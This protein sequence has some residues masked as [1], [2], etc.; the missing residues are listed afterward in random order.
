MYVKR[1]W[2]IHFDEEQYLALQGESF[3][4]LLQTPARLNTFR[5]AMAEVEQQLEP[6]ACW[7]HFPIQK[8]LHDKLVLATGSRIGGGPVVAVIGG[9]SELIVAICTIGPAVD[10]L[11]EMAQ[12]QRQHFRMMIL[13][14]LGAWAVDMVRQELCHWLEEDLQRQGLRVSTPLSPG[15]SAWSVK[16]QAVIFSLLDASQINVSLS[17]SMIMSPVKSLSL[18]IGTGT[19]PM[20][21]EGATNCD[22]CSIK[23][24]CTYRHKRA[25]IQP[26]PA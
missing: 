15:E 12:K 10:G 4:R 16:D 2:S 7:D 1:D 17:P 3:T 23:D 11:V 24:R 19:E 26:A 22:F 13:H 8:I 18:I 21:V 9:A 25:N 5:E 20:G 6:A 14:D